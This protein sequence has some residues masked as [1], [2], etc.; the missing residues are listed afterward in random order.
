MG[1]HV[2]F[3]PSVWKKGKNSKGKVCLLLSRGSFCGILYQETE[4]T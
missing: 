2:F 3:N 4:K 1:E